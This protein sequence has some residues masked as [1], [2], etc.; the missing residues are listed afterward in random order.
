MESL[1]GIN[2]TWQIDRKTILNWINKKYKISFIEPFNVQKHPLYKKVKN[3]YL[4]KMASRKLSKSKLVPGITV[5]L[6]Y[7]L[8]Q[9]I[10]GKD[11]GEDFI[12]LKASMPLPLFYISK[13]RHE[14]KKHIF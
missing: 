14:I 8:R 7:R 2:L 10:A 6:E 5:G 3:L 1:C 13:K 4:A 12:L 9:E 11:N